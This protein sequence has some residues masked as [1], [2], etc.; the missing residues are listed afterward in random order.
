MA[1]RVRNLESLNERWCRKNFQR[2]EIS[3]NAELLVL[4][5]KCLCRV[6]YLCILLSSL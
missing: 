6:A 4:K 2:H 1:Y 5:G 3:M